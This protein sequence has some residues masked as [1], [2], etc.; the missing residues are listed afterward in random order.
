MMRHGGS[1][2]NCK[3]IVAPDAVNVR[4][5]TTTDVPPALPVIII[6][7]MLRPVIVRSSFG[8]VPASPDSAMLLFVSEVMVDT[9]WLWALYA[10]IVTPWLCVRYALTLCWGVDKV[11]VIGPPASKTTLLPECGGNSNSF[12]EIPPVITVAF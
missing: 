11:I 2:M 9:S 1:G 4:S 7:V 12:N 10:C 6:L 5:S 3:D 8:W